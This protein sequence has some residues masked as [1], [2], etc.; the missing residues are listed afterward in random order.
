MHPKAGG[1]GLLLH[2]TDFKDCPGLSALSASTSTGF[3]EGPLGFPEQVLMLSVLISLVDRQHGPRKLPHPF[4]H[5]LLPQ[6][7]CLSQRD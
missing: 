6:N 4:S 3:P 2:K 1:A 5:Y 7:I